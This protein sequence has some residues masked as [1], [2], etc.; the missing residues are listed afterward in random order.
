MVMVLLVACQLI[1]MASFSYGFSSFGQRVQNSLVKPH[2]SP[3]SAVEERFNKMIDLDSP[4]VVN[5][6][7][8]K[9]KE[10]AVVCRCWQSG[11]Y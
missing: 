11:E 5:N 6:L 1:C 2:S 10:K 8:L 7:T 9:G 4:K 3:L